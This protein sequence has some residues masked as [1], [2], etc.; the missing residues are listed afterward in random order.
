[1]PQESPK[2]PTNAYIAATMQHVKDTVLYPRQVD[3]LIQRHI[4]SSR[5]ATTFEHE[6][7]LPTDKAQVRGLNLM[8][9]VIVLP[10]NVAIVTIPQADAFR[11]SSV[12]C[13]VI[14]IECDDS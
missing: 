2:E 11:V 1:M 4:E 10:S 9:G 7:C 6:W 3:N 14:V 5:E 13:C 12:V 8:N